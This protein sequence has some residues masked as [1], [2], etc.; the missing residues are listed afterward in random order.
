MHFDS[1]QGWMMAFGGPLLALI[2]GY[3]F[4]LMKSRGDV[5]AAKLISEA[6]IRVARAELET[7]VT[8][9]A[10]AIAQEHAALCEQVSQM[11][12]RLGQ[13]ELRLDKKDGE[14][15]D[16]KHELADKS[17]RLAELEK[18]PLCVEVNCPK[19][20]LLRKQVADL[21]AK[22]QVLEVRVA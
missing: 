15:E 18:L 16:L 20:T 22:L 8:K 9:K 5:S 19:L 4:S 14:I 1:V 13:L 17:V 3:F 7:A 6:N 10:A 21:E 12:A 2:I 11:F